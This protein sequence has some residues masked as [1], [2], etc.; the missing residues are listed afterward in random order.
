[1]MFV[2]CKTSGERVMPSTRIA[3]GDK[4]YLSLYAAKNMT[5][6]GQVCLRDYEDF[7]I[8][9]VSVENLPDGVSFS[10]HYA[11]CIAFHDGVPYPDILSNKREIHVKSHR[12]QGVWV[13][14]TVGENAEVKES[15]ITVLLKTSAGDFKAT[16]ALKVYPVTLPAPKDSALS[17]EY[18]FSATE[19]FPYQSTR[20]TVADRLP[21]F[22]RFERYSD[23]WWDLMK[24]VAQTM[25]FM[26]ANVF[27]LPTIELLID[28]G[29]K[30][31]GETTW[32]FHFDF[33]DR[34]VELFL[35]NGSFYRIVI[36]DHIDPADGKAIKAIDE[37]GKL[38][39]FDVFTEEADAW[40]EAFYTALY[41][42]FKEKGWL[43]MLFMHL[44][45]EPHAPQYWQWAREKCRAYMPDVRCGEPLDVHSVATQMDG[46]FDLY[47]PRVDIYAE[48][49]AY[50]QAKQQTGIP[51]W[52]YTCCYPEEHWWLNRFIDE[53]Q[54]YC[55][56]IMWACYSQG[57]TGYLHWG[58]NFWDSPILA[59][60][61]AGARFKGDGFIV[62][63]DGENNTLAL[64]ARLIAT[65]DG[66]QEYELLHMLSM[67]DERKAKE[68][69]ESVAKTFTE[70]SL[71]ETCADKARKM[72]LDL[73]TE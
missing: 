7:D 43:D 10:Y 50:Y 20:L 34:M 8:L 66:A 45:D 54:Q 46:Y 52:C 49:P 1:M 69:S 42:H 17:Q 21:N 47:I 68:L 31:T 70:F 62:Y 30:R 32:E 37:K 51:V 58:F 25:K 53:P 12:T 14:F 72:L 59:G 29:T 65:L 18:F 5:V 64:S 2:W 3:R 41:R 63:P 56:Q 73:L 9:G 11:E 48:D 55:R 38:C 67:R 39:H 33:V 6:S 40:A 71:D 61:Q 13:L 27:W 26:R 4:P 22:Y 35:G 15:E 60:V 57:I 23:E 44:Q 16:V 36:K 24:T 28:A 19:Y